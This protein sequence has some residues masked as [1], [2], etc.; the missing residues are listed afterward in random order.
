MRVLGANAFLSIVYY[1]ER[2]R[3]MKVYR[4]AKPMVDILADIEREQ[5]QIVEG[6]ITRLHKIGARATGASTPRDRGE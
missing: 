3:P 6:T 4:L 5:T 1:R 2:G